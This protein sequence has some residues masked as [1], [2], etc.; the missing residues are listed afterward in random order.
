MSSGFALPS[1]SQPTRPVILQATALS[2]RLHACFATLDDPRVERTRLHLLADILTIAILSILAGG[3]GWEDMRLYGIS[4]HAW[5]STFLALPN[6]IPSADTFRRV[7]ERLDPKQFEQCFERWVKQLIEDLKL[8]L[9]AI[10]GKC[11]KGSYDRE[12]G[13][14]ALHLVSA[15]ASEHRLVL[16]QAKVQDKS[17]EI[18]AIPVLLELLDLSGCIVTLD[19][20]G[21]QKSI[22]RQIHEAHADY[23][24]SLKLNHPTLFQQVEQGFQQA[25]SAGTLPA[26]C[27][28]TTE[29]GH[30]RIE[31]RTVWVLPVSAF[32]SLYQVDEWAGLQSIVMVER[33][34]RLWNK[35][36]HEVQF[37]LSSLPS[38]TLQ[39]ATAIR[40]HWGIENGLHWSLDVTFGEDVSRVRS[41]HA[42]HNL[43]LLRRFA[44]NALN[45]VEGKQSLRQ[46]SKRAAMDDNFMLR[47]LAAAL[48]DPSENPD[49]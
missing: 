18:T 10:D 28:H 6:G 38:E 21:T 26:P 37:Y 3:E 2:D 29:T 1:Q 36:T 4:K 20:M 19:A 17:N 9:I 7:F 45:R 35:T 22:A 23:I 34:R 27:E 11:V 41:L 49:P 24:L 14:S 42:P 48:P 47:V 31:T 43:S 39:I 5:L 12:A 8:R 15:W 16:A 32:A 46:K 44:V 33:T 25:R 40:Q 30:H 13:T